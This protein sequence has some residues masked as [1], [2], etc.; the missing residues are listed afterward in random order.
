MMSE[1]HA[2]NIFI[3]RQPT[4]PALPSLIQVAATHN[5]HAEQ[6]QAARSMTELVH[7]QQAA[8]IFRTSQGASKEAAPAL[9]G[10][11]NKRLL[12]TLNLHWASKYPARSATKL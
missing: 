6:E 12:A 7:V 8:E 4:Q 9:M 2:C 3:S 10:P 1:Q 11:G 5:C